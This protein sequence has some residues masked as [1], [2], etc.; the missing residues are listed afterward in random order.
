MKDVCVSLESTENV[1]VTNCNFKELNV[2]NSVCFVVH[3]YQALIYHYYGNCLCCSLFNSR[4]V[5]TCKCGGKSGD[6]MNAS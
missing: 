3:K 4:L 2:C 5:V 6:D 1:N